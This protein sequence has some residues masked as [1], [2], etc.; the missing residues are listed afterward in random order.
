[1]DSTAFVAGMS[2]IGAGIAALAVIGLSLIHIYCKSYMYLKTWSN[3][4]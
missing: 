2:A 4:P 1:M 3:N